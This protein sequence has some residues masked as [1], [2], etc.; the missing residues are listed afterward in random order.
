MRHFCMHDFTLLTLRF[1]MR[2]TTEK[3]M[4]HMRLAQDDTI[5]IVSVREPMDETI[6][7]GGRKLTTNAMNI[8]GDVLR[9][10]EQNTSNTKD[11]KSIGGTGDQGS[12]KYQ[13]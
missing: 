10:D 6:E 9:L 2:E 13:V 12:K 7:G 3:N 5:D 8:D 1:V 4:N 11:P